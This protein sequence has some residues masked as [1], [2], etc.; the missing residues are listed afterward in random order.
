MME[1]ISGILFAIL[2]AV[3]G[4][5]TPAVKDLVKSNLD[6]WTAAAAKTANPFDDLLVRFIRTLLGM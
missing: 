3:V 5:A 2:G 6:N 4:A 1:K